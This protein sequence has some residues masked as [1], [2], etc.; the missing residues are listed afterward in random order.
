MILLQ[1]HGAQKSYSFQGISWHMHRHWVAFIGGQ[2]QVFV[3]DFED[4]GAGPP[5]GTKTY[6]IYSEKLLLLFVEHLRF[7]RYSL[8]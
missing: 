1:S 4:A 7:Y 5:S 6:I 8:I 3:H 2:D